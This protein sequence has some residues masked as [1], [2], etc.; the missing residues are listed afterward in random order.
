MTE[1]AQLAAR[2]GT[3][4]PAS[5]REYLRS[6]LPALYR[7]DPR[8]TAQPFALRFVAGLEE[9]LDPIVAMLDLLPAHLDVGIAPHRFVALFGSWLG[10][11]L[12]AGLE[13]DRERLLTAH[14]RMVRNAAKLTRL[15]G[16]HRG[17]ERLLE[18]AFDDLDFDVRDSGGVTSSDDPSDLQPAADP[19][20][21]IVYPRALLA[22]PD[23][24]ASVRRVVEDVRPAGVALELLPAEEEAE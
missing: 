3:P 7:D 14:R 20:L 17:I 15:R 24:L 13:A 11:E 19:A 12:D 9:V 1:V 6:G 8:T 23:R 2:N 22:D 4:A 18:L 5:G 21:T 16:T 10:L